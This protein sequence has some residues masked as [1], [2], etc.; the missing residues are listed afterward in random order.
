MIFGKFQIFD[1]RIRILATP[2]DLLLNGSVVEQAA[3][4]AR[5]AAPAVPDDQKHVPASPQCSRM[6]TQGSGGPQGGPGGPLP[7]QE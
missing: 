5:G 3:R 6:T 2:G 7:A 4:D 1:Y